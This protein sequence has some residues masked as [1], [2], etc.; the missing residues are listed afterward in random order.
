MPVFLILGALLSCFFAAASLEAR[1]ARRGGEAVPI[2]DI[3][4]GCK[5]LAQ[6]DLN[7][8]T[9]Y[10]QC[11]AEEQTA[12]AQLQTAW[13]SFPADKREECMYL[14]TPPALPSYVTLQECLDTA[15]EAGRLSK[16]GPGKYQPGA[17]NLR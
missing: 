10:S 5:D 16:S 11:I 6:M 3:D 15:R 17:P 13:S 12:R 2:L 8:T 7:K 1:T 4:A 9:N 14:V